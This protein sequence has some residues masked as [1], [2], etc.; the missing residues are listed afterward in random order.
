[1]CR[2]FQENLLLITLFYR[3]SYQKKSLIV[4]DVPLHKVLSY[5]YVF[6]KEVQFSKSHQILVLLSHKISSVIIM[7][8]GL[9]Q[10]NFIHISKVSW[11]IEDQCRKRTWGLANYFSFSSRKELTTTR[12]PIYN[13]LN[14]YST[15]AKISVKQTDSL[16]LISAANM[17][18]N[19]QPT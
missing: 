12:L 8:V 4:H 10:K 3:I 16:N 5:K 6:K 18:K 1:M 9:L 2:T 7:V 13:H 11:V 19:N 15:R 14:Y 17:K